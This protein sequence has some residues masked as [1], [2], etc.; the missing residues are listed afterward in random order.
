MVKK[1]KRI[2]VILLLF[3]VTVV[4][5]LC[6]K[7]VMTKSDNIIMADLVLKHDGGQNTN[8]FKISESQ[9]ESLQAILLELCCRNTI[10]Y[11][12]NDLYNNDPSLILYVAYTTAND[13]VGSFSMTF[14]TDYSYGPIIVDSGNVLK[15]IIINHDGLEHR[16]YGLIEK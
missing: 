13:Q 16:I 4:I 14:W 15:Q 6:P 5:L 2:V 12:A 3:A 8:F 7:H 9:Y 10:V 1:T 11:S